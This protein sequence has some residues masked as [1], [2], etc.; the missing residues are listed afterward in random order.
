MR[1]DQN[2]SAN[3]HTDDTIS[4][5]WYQSSRSVSLFMEMRDA[6]SWTPWA[7]QISSR[8]GSAVHTAQASGSLVLIC[9]FEMCQL[10]KKA[11]MVRQV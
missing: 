2:L 11:D 8:K 7:W 1:L 5:H 4:E 6:V 10:G 3:S 9:A